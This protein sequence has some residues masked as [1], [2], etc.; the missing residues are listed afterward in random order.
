MF[1]LPRAGGVINNLHGFMGCIVPL[2]APRKAE[3]PQ[4]FAKFIGRFYL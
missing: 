3:S 1:Q 2:L 4:E